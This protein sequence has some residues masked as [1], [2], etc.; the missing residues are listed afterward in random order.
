MSKVLIVDD[1]EQYIILLKQYLEERGFR[2]TCFSNGEEALFC[3]S[4]EFFDIVVCDVL[5]PMF[6]T[7]EGGIEIAR[8][9]GEKYPA[10][11]TIIISQYV[12]E[13][14][15]NRFM[16]S[17][18]RRRFRFLNK[19]D[20]MAAQLV[21]EIAKAS[22]HKYVFVS[23]QF[24][25]D[26][27]DIYEF[28]IKEAVQE[29]GYKCQRADE[30]KNVVG[31]IEKVQDLIRSAHFIIA[32]VSTKNA[33]VFYEIGYAHALGKEVIL[34]AKDDT[35]IVTNLSNFVHLVYNGKIV[36]LKR[37]IKEH[38]EWKNSEML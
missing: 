28:G 18:P 20:N 4:K 24:D 26:Y 5:L 6:G 14:L 16:Q 17:V 8:Y 38:L 34:L 27:N 1:D 33:N 29:A 21:T 19:S 37:R 10:A 12:T 35:C 3:L 30:V 11:Q 23:M 25:N 22:S 36:E 31:I 7:Q 13:L 2:V 15:V 32:E 9:V